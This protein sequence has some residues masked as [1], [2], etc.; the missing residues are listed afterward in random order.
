VLEFELG[1]TDYRIEREMGGKSLTMRAELRS[2]STVVATG[3][4][5]VKKAVEKL[6]GMDHKS[7][8]TSVFARQKELNALQ[9]VASGERKKVVL[10]MLRIDG[11]DA[12]V[13]LIRTDA[14]DIKERIKGAESTLV[15]EDGRDR[16]SVLS[17]RLPKLQGQREEA[18]GLLKE[19]ETKEAVALKAVDEARS[20]R[21]LLKKDVD[22]YNSSARDLTAKRSAI[23]ELRKREERLAAR[24]ADAKKKLERLPELE[25]AEKAWSENV[26]S[27]DALEAERSKGEKAKHLAEDIAVIS[28]DETRAVDEISK[29]RAALTKP[30]DI[31]GQIDELEKARAES[32]A[33]KAEISGRIGELKAKR[34]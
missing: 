27:K 4:K 17:D 6:I 11:V 25:S 29:L 2:G 21:D 32:E 34:K 3:D 22:A 28:K 1:G 19:A 9:N 30:S 23:S 33:A 7:F 14:R 10:R 26:R 12:V 20:R 8:F 13:Q 24:V 18:E 15:D 31:V 16:Q 5:P